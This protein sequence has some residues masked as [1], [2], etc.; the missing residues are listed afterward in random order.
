[1]DEEY[2]DDD[3]FTIMDLEGFCDEL[4]KFVNINMGNQES[5]WKQMLD[6]VS[7]EQVLNHVTNNSIGYD[8]ENNVIITAKGFTDIASAVTN[9]VTGTMLSKLAAE[10]HLDCYWDDEANE[11]MFMRAE[12]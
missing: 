11:M 10:G 5:Q 6:F 1:M 8:E 3:T 12:N 4:L 2:S 7:K 9:D